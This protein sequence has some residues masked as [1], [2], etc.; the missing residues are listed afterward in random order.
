[1]IGFCTDPQGICSILPQ[2]FL[3]GYDLAP[4]PLYISISPDF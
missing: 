4:L 2:K 1:M 3:K